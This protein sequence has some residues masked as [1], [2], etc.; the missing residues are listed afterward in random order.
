MDVTKLEKEWGQEFKEFKSTVPVDKDLLTEISS[1][2]GALTRLRNVKAAADKS[3]EDWEKLKNL[4]TSRTRTCGRPWL[5]AAATLT[6]ESPAATPPSRPP[7]AT[8]P[9]PTPA[10]APD[11]VAPA[12]PAAPAVA[13]RNEAER[14][15]PT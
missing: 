14:S 6:T 11:T 13:A 12:A 7:L 1:V 10:A 8:A 15:E 3:N 5:A 2:Q 9:V 4:P